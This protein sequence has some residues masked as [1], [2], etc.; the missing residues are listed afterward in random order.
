MHCLD[1]LLEVIDLVNI[2]LLLTFKPGHFLL[3]NRQLFA[4][5]LVLVFP[6]SEVLLAVS[7][8]VDLLGTLGGVNHALGDQQRIMLMSF[9]NFN[10]GLELGH[11][12]GGQLNS[13]N[14]DRFL[15]L[16][17]ASVELFYQHAFLR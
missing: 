14:L 16:H 17:E 10:K 3:P 2:V 8:N 15:E 11:A 9:N 5:L 6:L 1:A 4:N 13:L 7:A 12:D